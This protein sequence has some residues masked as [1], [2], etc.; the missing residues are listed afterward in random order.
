MFQCKGRFGNSSTF[1]E[2][3]DRLSNKGIRVKEGEDDDDE[4]IEDPETD[5]SNDTHTKSEDIKNQFTKS[6][7]ETST[8][9]LDQSKRMM[10]LFERSG[11][12]S[13][14]G[15]NRSM[16][17]RLHNFNH[18]VKV[19]TDSNSEVTNERIELDDPTFDLRIDKF[20][21]V[22]V[23]RTFV[24][25]DFLCLDRTRMTSSDLT[26]VLKAVNM[27]TWVTQTHMDSLP[28]GTFFPRLTA[29]SH[30]LPVRVRLLLLEELEDCG[31]YHFTKDMGND[32]FVVWN[33]SESD[34]FTYIY[35]RFETSKKEEITESSGVVPPALF[36][37]PEKELT[38]RHKHLVDLP[39]AETLLELIICDTL[40]FSIDFDSM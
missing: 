8:Q 36:F 22:V 34:L 11:D 24:K 1:D 40:M 30:V 13:L 33:N 28:K 18:R 17:I 27:T 32:I 5:N 38:I 29:S 10:I 12:A 3:F 20:P 2:L 37:S 39:A 9:N 14:F 26:S 31:F 21:S 7:T 23:V 16:V 6:D 15:R 4:E 35:K 19:T 25:G